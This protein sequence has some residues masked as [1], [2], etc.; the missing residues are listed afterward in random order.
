[1][2]KLLKYLSKKDR[3][4]AFL[5]L[6]LVAGQVWF[7]LTMPD[8]MSDIFHCAPGGNDQPCDVTHKV[9]HG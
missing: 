8:F 5:C 3:F 9:G 4:Y 6:L 1:M 7:D 2:L